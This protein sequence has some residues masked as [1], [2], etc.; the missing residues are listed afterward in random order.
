[1]QGEKPR[2]KLDRRRKTAG[3]I[4][5]KEKNRGAKKGAISTGRNTTKEQLAPGETPRSIKP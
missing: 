4:R 5:Q 1:M 3:E 2:E